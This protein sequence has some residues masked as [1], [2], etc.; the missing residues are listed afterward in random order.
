MKI[1]KVEYAG[2]AGET[3][4]RTSGPWGNYSVT[5]EQAGVVS[6]LVGDALLNAT[7]RAPNV[8]DVGLENVSLNYVS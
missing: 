5:I 3:N 6:V 1:L 8:H 2:E 7:G 4:A